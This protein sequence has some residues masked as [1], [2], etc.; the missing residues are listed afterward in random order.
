MGGRERTL[1]HYRELAATA[2]LTVDRTCALPLDFSMI[3]LSHSVV[4]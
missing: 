2:G 3:E 4:A 1:N